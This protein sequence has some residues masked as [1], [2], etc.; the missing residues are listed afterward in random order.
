MLTAGVQAFNDHPHADM[1][2]FERIG[3]ARVRG[4]AIHMQAA[5]GTMNQPEACGISCGRPMLDQRERPLDPRPVPH[6]PMLGS[7]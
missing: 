5:I 3:P 6:H 1:L 4:F 7:Q 2:R